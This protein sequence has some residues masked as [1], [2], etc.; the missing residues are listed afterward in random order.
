MT[1]AAACM[2]LEGPSRAQRRQQATATPS[3][4]ELTSP[5][6]LRLQVG[7]NHRQN[8]WISLRQA[9]RGDL[10]F[11]AQECPGSHVVLKGSE[12][13]GSGQRSSGR[14][15]SGRPLQPRPRQPARGR[16]DGALR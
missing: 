7:R 15:R 11:H 8:E 10:W 5:G 2:R 3:P 13:L 4:L 9:R 14:S 16:G 12:G 6:G 1:S